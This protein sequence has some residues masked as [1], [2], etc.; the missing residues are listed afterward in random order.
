M[1]KRRRLLGHQEP[2]RAPRAETPNPRG[3]EREGNGKPPA[4]ARRRR[5]DQQHKADNTILRLQRRGE[6]RHTADQKNNPTRRNTTRRRTGG[7]Y[8]APAGH[9]FKQAK[10]RKRET[11]PGAQ[12]GQSHQARDDRT[13]QAESGADRSAG[14]PNQPETRANRPGTTA[15][16]KRR[17]GPT[18]TGGPGP[19]RDPGAGAGPRRGTPETGGTDG[20]GPARTTTTR[21]L[22]ETRGKA[23]ARR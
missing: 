7:E 9:E 16:A 15:P 8:P 21:R 11:N 10:S 19:A 6:T 12:L 18:T 17:A 23:T 14:A 1:H 3:R 5:G 2:E 20:G 4:K 22:N 13:R